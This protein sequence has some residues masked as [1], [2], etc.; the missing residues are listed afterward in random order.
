LL[1]AGHLP[2]GPWRRLVWSLPAGIVIA[3]TILTGFLVILAEAPLS[4]PSHNSIALRIIELPP[5]PAPG[6]NPPRPTPT[7]RASKSESSKPV[8]PT[9]VDAMPMIETTPAPS[10][11]VPQPGPPK[12]AEPMP[13][14]VLPMI[15]TAAPPRPKSMPHLDAL[16]S[17]PPTKPKPPRLQRTL[18]RA[19]AQQSRPAPQTAPRTAAPNGSPTAAA[20]SSGSVTM[21]ARALYKPM[22][23]FPEELRRRP[24]NVVAVAS[25]HVGA[26]GSATV[27]LVQATVDPLINA[28]LMVALHKW[29]FIPALENGHPVASI[30]EIRIPIVVR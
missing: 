21:G 7:E 6:D 19:M 16:P 28:A 5:E 2:D 24:W 4:L 15:K 27:T 18:R 17:P 8:E 10:E 30:I 26:D 29:R 13:V 12:P 9:P 3:G 1:V 22:P 14:D 23:D 11:N 20:A 25:F